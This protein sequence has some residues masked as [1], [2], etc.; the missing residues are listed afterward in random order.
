[1]YNGR[2]D[3]RNHRYTQVLGQRQTVGLAAEGSFNQVCQVVGII[4]YS[5]CVCVV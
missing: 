4:Q 1:M 2:F 3:N 5:D